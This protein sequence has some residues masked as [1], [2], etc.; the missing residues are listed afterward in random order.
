MF[1][2]YP[3]PRGGAEHH[4]GVGEDTGSVA[5]LGVDVDGLKGYIHSGE[6]GLPKFLPR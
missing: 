3:R 2:R 6:L 1:L 4:H 5:G